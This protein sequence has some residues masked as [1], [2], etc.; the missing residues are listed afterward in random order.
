MTCPRISAIPLR[1]R[2]QLAISGS[3]DRRR[4]PSQPPLVRV[5]PACGRPGHVAVQ[6][7]VLV[8]SFLTA[9]MITAA[10][11][12]SASHAPSPCAS[13]A[14]EGRTDGL[15]DQDTRWPVLVLV[16]PKGWTGLEAVDGKKPRAPGAP[17]RSP[18]PTWRPTRSTSRSSTPGCA[19]T[20]RTSCSTPRVG[21]A[22]SWR[23]WARRR[24]SHGGQPARQR[25]TPARGSSPPDFREYAT[26]VP[27]PAM[28]VAEATRV[29]GELSSGSYDTQP[30]PTELPRVRSRRDCVEP[31]RRA[32]RGDPA[33]LDGRPTP[34]T[35]TS[36]PTDG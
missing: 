24:S 2:A 19:A 36:P 14:G 11:E 26:A 21:S 34:R 28:V 13:E 29:L 7:R 1:T 12:A 6:A 31:A 35:T 8:G 20:V 5:G 10:R 4:A 18:S 22:T 16:T 25:G 9:I 3:P 23:H 32:V 30:G 17:I 15:S 33:H 27:K